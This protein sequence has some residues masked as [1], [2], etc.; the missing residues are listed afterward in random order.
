VTDVVPFGHK[1]DKAVG[2]ATVTPVQ[3]VPE[4]TAVTISPA[5][6]PVPSALI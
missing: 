1:A 4:G 5:A 6:N 3:G 2:L